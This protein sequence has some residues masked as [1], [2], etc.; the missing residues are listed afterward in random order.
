[1][2]GV[3]GSPHSRAR[4]PGRMLGKCLGCNRADA[5][6]G[7]RK[8]EFPPSFNMAQSALGV[9]PGFRGAVAAP[10]LLR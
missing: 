7:E 9:M 10:A 8:L 1:M 6:E 5:K 4:L 2:R 3:W